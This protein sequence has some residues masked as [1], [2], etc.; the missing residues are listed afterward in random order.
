MS[1]LRVFS[2]ALWMLWLAMNAS[3]QAQS[4]ITQHGYTVH[5]NAIPSV[6]LTPE[7]ARNYGLT[8]SAQRAV[9]NIAVRSAG[10]SASAHAVSAQVQAVATNSTGQRQNLRMREVR[11][12]ESIYAIGEL[13]IDE[14]ELYQFEVDVT[15]AGESRTIKLHFSQSLFGELR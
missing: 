12:Q 5:Y 15:P 2:L 13:R 6:L 11:E 1:M 3:A 14:G 7:V 10:D 9:L 4:S 8:R